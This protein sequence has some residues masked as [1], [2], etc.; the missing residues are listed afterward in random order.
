[1]LEKIDEKVS[2]VTIYSKEKSLAM[3]VKLKWNDKVYV[4]NKLGYHHKY[5]LG[6]TL[7]HVFSV[8][9]SS[10]AFRLEFNSDTLTWTLMEVS[11]GLGV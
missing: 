7:I 10:L 2:V 5:K 1:M 8:S 4:I 11:D 6:K 3:P 9:N